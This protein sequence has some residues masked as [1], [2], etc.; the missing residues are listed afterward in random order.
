M[1]K[2]KNWSVERW[3]AIIIVATILNKISGFL[4]NKIS[5]L[6]DY[7]VFDFIQY[8]IY[9]V[10]YYG[11]SIVAFIYTGPLL[12]AIFEIALELI[13]KKRSK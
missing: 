1:S 10:V 12:V 6:F 13:T 3:V 7:Y 4:A 9:Y 5:I 8:T 11:F 2:I